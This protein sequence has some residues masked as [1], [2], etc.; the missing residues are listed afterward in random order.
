MRPIATRLEVASLMFGAIFNTSEVDKYADWVIEEVKRTLPAGFDPNMRNVA[1]RADNL[2]NR[3]AKQ[4]EKFV[5]TTK[6]N[7]YK[8][9]R[10]ASRVRDGMLANGY[11]EPFVKA[12]SMD[13]IKRI[14]GY[15]KRK[16]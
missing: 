6:L 16:D 13:L 15:K 2:N 5:G 10:L 1:E 11:P 7:I 14:E 12:L 4:T 3:I 9:A 8:K